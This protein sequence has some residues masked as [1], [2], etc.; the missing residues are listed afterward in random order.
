MTHDEL[1]SKL[2]EQYN[3]WSNLVYYTKPEFY[4]NTV[5]QRNSWSALLAVVNLHKPQDFTNDKGNVN[6]NHCEQWTY[7]CPT[8]HDIKKEL[9]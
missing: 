9:R 5:D 1:V 2:K 8:I 4:E 6:C 3:Y 7:P